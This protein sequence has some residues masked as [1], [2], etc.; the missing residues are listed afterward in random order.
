MKANNQELR[1]QFSALTPHCFCP[2]VRRSTVWLNLFLCTMSP[3]QGDCSHNPV[4]SLGASIAK[5]RSW[6]S[7]ELFPSHY[8]SQ[9]LHRRTG[10]SNLFTSLCLQFTHIRPTD[11]HYNSITQ[12]LMSADKIVIS[13]PD[14]DLIPFTLRRVCGHNSKSIWLYYSHDHREKSSTLSE[15]ASGQ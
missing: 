10:E 11:E 4:S 7:P 6:A 5:T 8:S 14:P 15:M 13:T 3:V 12:S 2:A 1:R 9:H